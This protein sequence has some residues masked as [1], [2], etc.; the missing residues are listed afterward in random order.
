MP[1]G[2]LGK[3]ERLGEWS[4]TP[5]VHWSKTA[6]FCAICPGLW[7][8]TLLQVL[9]LQLSRSPSSVVS[10][11]AA[12]GS[13]SSYDTRLHATSGAQT[14]HMQNLHQPSLL[15]WLGR[16]GASSV[17]W[18]V[19]GRALRWGRGRA[20]SVLES[21]LLQNQ[22]HNAPE[23]QRSELYHHP[24]LLIPPA[25]PPLLARLVSLCLIPFLQHTSLSSFS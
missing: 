9:S 14:C 20:C 4:K 25:T 3:L 24:Q 21:S 16:A 19:V 1:E 2:G 12:A 15:K 22:L 23:T 6:D 13:G 17:L 8:W 11:C 18:A 10:W 5:D 7:V